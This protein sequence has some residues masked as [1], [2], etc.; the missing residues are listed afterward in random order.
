VYVIRKM[1]QSENIDVSSAAEVIDK[2]R[3]GM[4]KMRSYKVFQQALVDARDLCSS[5]E[6]EAEFQEPQVRPQKKEA[7]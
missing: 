3:Q 4:V 6:T 1:L 7:I 5:I 2:G